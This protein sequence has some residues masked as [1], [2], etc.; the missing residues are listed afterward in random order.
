MDKELVYWNE[1]K[2]EC[3]RLDGVGRMVDVHARPL[4]S[5]YFTAPAPN[6]FKKNCARFM[7]IL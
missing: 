5:N 7:G 4:L 2:A 1:L 6:K 3:I